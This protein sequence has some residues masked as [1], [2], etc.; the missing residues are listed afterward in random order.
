MM[1]ERLYLDISG[2]AGANG[3]RLQIKKLPANRSE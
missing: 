1:D 2:G 3:S